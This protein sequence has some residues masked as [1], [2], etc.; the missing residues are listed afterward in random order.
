MRFR[1]ESMT[2]V[3]VAVTADGQASGK[4][5]ARVMTLGVTAATRRIMAAKRDPKEA[6]S[7]EATEKMAERQNQEKIWRNIVEKTR[8]GE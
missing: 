4:D 8:N 3:Q 2:K 1:K 5:V 6:E 7:K